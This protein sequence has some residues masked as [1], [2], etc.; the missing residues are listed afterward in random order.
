[1]NEKLNENESLRSQL[2]RLNLQVFNFNIKLY[3]IFKKNIFDFEVYNFFKLEDNQYEL[4]QFRLE[5]QDYKLIILNYE[6]EIKE[7]NKGM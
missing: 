6:K 3:S 2:N 4:Q 7:L 1:M 5:I